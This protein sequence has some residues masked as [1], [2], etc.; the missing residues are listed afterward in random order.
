VVYGRLGL[1][2]ELD[3]RLWHDSAEQRDADLDRDL[4]AAVVGMQTVRLGWGQV[5]HR[6]CDTAV[7]LGAVLTARGWTGAVA[8]CSRCPYPWP[9]TG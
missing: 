2:V 8:R 6:P 7:R 9:L 3:G 1:V 5:F 4:D